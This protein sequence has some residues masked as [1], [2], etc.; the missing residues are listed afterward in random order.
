MDRLDDNAFENRR[1]SNQL[2]VDKSGRKPLFASA[3]SRDGGAR[4]DASQH[5]RP[6]GGRRYQPPIDGLTNRSRHE[7]PT[8][9][10]AAR[11]TTQ[12]RPL[13]S[14]SR[15]AQAKGSSIS[16]RKPLS[17][18]EA[19]RLAEQEEDG[20]GGEDDGPMAG[21]PSP[22]P[23]TWRSRFNSQMKATEAGRE[24]AKVTRGEQGVAVAG[25]ENPSRSP[26]GRYDYAE[27]LINVPSEALLR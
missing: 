3:N 1:S 5:P 2:L 21:S 4:D 19:Y 13:S 11:G 25:G 24:L 17:M 23:R 10:S 26:N 6:V 7:P 15:V 8:P 27:V 14:G 22:A 9:S 20:S 18:S 16:H 12:A